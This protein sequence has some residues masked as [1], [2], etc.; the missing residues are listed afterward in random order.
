[1]SEFNNN[2]EN[3]EMD[4]LVTAMDEDGNEVTL[5]ILDYFFYNGEEYCAFSIVDNEEDPCT[6]CEACAEEDGE[7]PDCNGC[8]NYSEVSVDVICKV[9]SGVDEDG[10]EVDSFIPV[11]DEEMIE[12]LFKVFSAQME[13][14]EEA[15]DEE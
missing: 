7:T 6:A 1:M 13:E 15:D 10:T 5:R 14:D 4:D 9:E 11:E 8:E 12:K 2:A 3:E